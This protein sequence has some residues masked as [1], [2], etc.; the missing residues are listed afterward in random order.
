[1]APVRRLAAWWTTRSPRFRWSLGLAGSLLACALALPL[2]L[3]VE[4]QKG[5]GPALSAADADAAYAGLLRRHVDEGG[6]RYGSLRKEATLLGRVVR[7]WGETG[8]VS[9]PA[10]FAA[11]TE[12]LA[13]YLNAY[14]GFVLYGV[15][16]HPGITSVRDVHGLLEP[17]SGMGFFWAQRF[18]LDGRWLTLHGLENEIIRGRFRDARVH[19]ALNCASASCPALL[20][21]PFVA[22]KLSQQLTERA[23]LFASSAPHV[24]VDD[25]RREIALS[26]IFSWYEDDFLAE[27]RAHGGRDVLDWIMLYA[28]TPTRASLERAR[29]A[30]YAVRFVPYDWRL[31]Q[32]NQEGIHRSR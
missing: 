19:A 31:N 30:S 12:R 1:M 3:G 25:A 18:K 28:D 11:D 8:P 2:L 7:S 27:A 6:V 32:S 24:R 13:Y 9:E 15:T 22:S 5:V 29:N 16:R 17:T 26:Q 4:L 14:N 20:H 21:E 23:S 10:R